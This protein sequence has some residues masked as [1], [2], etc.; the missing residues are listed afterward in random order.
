MERLVFVGAIV[1][2]A[3]YALCTFW[4]P[5]I[6]FGDDHPMGRIDPVMQVAAGN[7]APQS[8]SATEVDVRYAAAMVVVTPEDRA[9]ISVEI[10]NPGQLPMPTVEVDGN[11][12]TINGHLRGRIG[13]CQDGGGARVRGYG[14]FNGDQLPRI[15]IRTPRNVHY[16]A[17]G[18]VSTQIGSA[19]QVNASFSGCA[20]STIGDVAGT[21]DLDV[22]GS[23]DVR[24]GTAQVL[25]VDIAG[26][27]EVTTGA[28]SQS[29]NIE[30]AGSGEV[31]IASLTGSL[32]SEG[33]GSG[34]L[35]I[36][37][38]AI[39]NARLEM[40]GSGEANIAATVQNLEVEIVGSGDVDVTAAVVNVDADI[41]GS[42]S[43][44]VKSASGSVRRSIMGS[45]E[46]NI[47]A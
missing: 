32:E 14:E 6:S 17:G 44:T 27:S 30:I 16:S 29:A 5:N 4:G 33:A 10:A 36:Q 7:M 39:T 38:G 46:L 9:D 15:T 31:T 28:I 43:V 22:A 1:I 40:A 20:D 45:G 8:Y 42:G 25:N 3:I 12:V 13:D 35:T 37:A 24:T 2:A 23:G 34:N 18:A 47:G 26:N 21:L 41:A 19:N 11:E